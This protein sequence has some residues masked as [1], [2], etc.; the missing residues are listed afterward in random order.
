MA[1]EKYNEFIKRFNISQKIVRPT[2]ISNVFKFQPRDIADFGEKG[3]TVVSDIGTLIEIKVEGCKECKKCMK[4]CPENAILSVKD[5]KIL[6]SSSL[7]LGTACRRC[8]AAC[9]EKILDFNKK[10]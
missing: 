3:L 8:V 1:L 4:S 7:C 9:P 10:K 2:K 5:G 6:I